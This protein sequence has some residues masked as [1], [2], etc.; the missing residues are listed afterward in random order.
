MGKI[1]AGM[2]ALI[3]M[4]VANAFGAVLSKYEDAKMRAPVYQ[5]L[6]GYDVVAA[7]RTISPEYISENIPSKVEWTSQQL[8]YPY[9]IEI[10]KVDPPYVYAETVSFPL[11]KKI[12][13]SFKFEVRKEE[14]TYYLV[15]GKYEF[16]GDV[17]WVYPYLEMK[18]V[19]R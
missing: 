15:P 7:K 16:H 8:R 17:L 13:R 2:A 5:F 1:T 4:I 10:K 18:E 19:T 14:W 9:T 3:I 11:D 6:A 12:V